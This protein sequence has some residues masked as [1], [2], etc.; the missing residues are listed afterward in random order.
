MEVIQTGIDGLVEFRPRIFGDDRGWF[1]ETF[2]ENKYTDHLPAGTRFIQDNLSFSNKGVLRGLHF[3]DPPF[4]QA[5][6]VSV[7]Q[8]KVLDIAVDL[9]KDS[10]TYGKS[11][12]VILDSESKNQLFVPRGFAHGFSSLEDGTI[13]A[14][15]CDNIYAKDH[16]RTIQWND[17]MLA[18]DWKVKAPIL[19][20]KDMVGE[21]F[22]SFVT[23]F[24]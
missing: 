10:K 8:G 15:K 4:A 7:I 13:F 16:E 1:L 19:A 20:D 22:S 17:P 12:A 11:Y 21:S 18:I 3:Q 14:Y 6:L 9:R 5:K 2:N 24:Y 23:P